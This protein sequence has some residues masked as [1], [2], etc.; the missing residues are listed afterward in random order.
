MLEIQKYLTT[1]VA[2][3]KKKIW[4]LNNLMP[5]KLENLDLIDKSQKNIT[6]QN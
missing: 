3:I 1:D 2:Y 6:D 4:S 5:P